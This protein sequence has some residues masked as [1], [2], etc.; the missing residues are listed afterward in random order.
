LG[1][2]NWLMVGTGAS[3]QMKL[4]QD[5]LESYD[6]KAKPTW[7][8]NKVQNVIILLFF[9]TFLNLFLNHFFNCSLLI[10]LSFNRSNSLSIL[11]CECHIL[12]G[13]VPNFGIGQFFWAQLKNGK[14]I[15]DKR[16]QKFYEKK[17]K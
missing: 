9:F 17:A 4:I 5:M 12:H 15:Y 13:F 16:R 7:D 6:R 1:T 11:A 2:G 14:K 3:N 10:D 8:N